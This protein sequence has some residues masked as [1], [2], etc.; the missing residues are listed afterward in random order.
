MHQSISKIILAVV[1]FIA[2]T[3]AGTTSFAAQRHLFFG[4]ERL[5][6]TLITAIGQTPDGFLWVGTENGLAR[7]DGYHFSSRTSLDGTQ[8]PTVATSLLSDANGRL[9]VGTSHGL[10][11]IDCTTGDIREL[12]FP[13]S[14]Q[15]RVY[16]LIASADN[17]LLAGT[18]GYGLF[19]VD[20]MTFEVTHLNHAGKPDSLYATEPSMAYVLNLFRSPD[21]TL[22][23]NSNNGVI[24]LITPDGRYRQMT[25]SCGTPVGF[26]QRDRT[27]YALC[28]HGLEPLTGGAPQLYVPAQ[29][30]SF[31][32]VAADGE[33]NIYAGTHGSG[34]LW[35]P[36]G[37]NTF[38][39]LNISMGDFDL[40]H[41]RVEALYVDLQGNLWAGCYGR[42]L[43]AVARQASTAFQT[44]S[45]AAQRHA[46]GTYISS[47]AE[48]TAPV[49]Y[50]ATVQGDDIYGFD[51]DGNII[52]QLNAPAGLETMMRASDG[53]YWLGTQNTLYRFDTMTGLARFHASLPGDRIASIIELGPT[54]LAVSTYGA[55]V[56]IV[57]RRQPENVVQLSMYDTDTLHRGRLINDWV[58]ALDVDAKG[59][60]WAATS[61]GVCR[62]DPSTATF[63]PDTM[64]RQLRTEDCSALRV[65]RSG[66]VLMSTSAGIMRWSETQGLRPEPA[67]E[68]LCQRSVAYI[69]E[70]SHGDIW[71]STN[72][73]LWRLQ[74]DSAL[75]TPF[76]A[77]EEGHAAEY[78]VR[79]G[80][81]AADGSML[82]ATSDAITIFKPS[83][84]RNRRPLDAKIRQT[85]LSFADGIWHA[86]F[87]LMDFMNTVGTVFEYRFADDK[88]WQLLPPG[89]NAITFRHLAPG[90]YRLFVRAT[91][92][93]QTTEPQAYCFEVP[94]PWWQTSWAYTIYV[95]LFIAI[96]AFAAFAYR[97]HI[98][99]QLDREK[100]SFLINATQDQATPLSLDD[101]QTAIAHYVQSRRQ[102]HGQMVAQVR[103]V[104]TMTKDIDKPEVSGNDEQL[105]ARITK[106]VNRH[107]GDSDFTV[108]QMCEEVGISR[109]HLHRKMKELTGFAVTEF[110]R[111]IRLEQAARLLREQK[112][113]IT[114]VAYT[115]GFSNLGYFS[116]VFRKHFGISPRDFISQH[117]AATAIAAE[118][119]ASAP[120]ASN[121]AHDPS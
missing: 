79:A 77:A 70:D 56:A 5:R 103:N 40:D 35:L 10:F 68:K 67:T 86:E 102:Q 107:L 82:F 69:A 37:E 71:F 27:T 114:Q 111:N 58:H 104:E 62:Y 110:I 11:F 72:D 63:S 76:M 42:G 41:A 52:R 50:W 118:P 20:P 57:D 119:D 24:S 88:A 100:L 30:Y 112:L 89:D 95:L 49:A 43:L 121:D 36:R 92:A 46:T 75:L 47:L 106:S 21:G 4:P 61:S 109:A 85:A 115:V 19:D 26:F 28:Q 55:G 105:M 74:A 51:G 101:L 29:P 87:S 91:F 116:T 2:I 32:C 25:A 84:L 48:G 31:T 120:P 13:D 81:Q 34:L 14:L 45:F 7:F 23:S 8:R 16:S 108:E 83:L 113:N 65:L 53:T 60:L 6:S 33:G 99:H 117:N 22:W 59:R 96:A 15:P 78:V 3:A 9:W 98:Q 12:C 93:G 73:G 17:R 80:L 94:P 90:V 54:Q 39:H 64:L 1:S 18:A 97:R 38:R 66:D 44:W